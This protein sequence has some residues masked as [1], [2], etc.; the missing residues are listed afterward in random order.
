MIFRSVEYRI[1]CNE[2]G[3]YLSCDNNNSAYYGISISEVSREHIKG[4]ARRQGW[5]VE[6]EIC[7]ECI[8]NK[9]QLEIL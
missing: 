3:E 4:E 6:K 1:N 2:C 7:K 9:N 5:D 8:E